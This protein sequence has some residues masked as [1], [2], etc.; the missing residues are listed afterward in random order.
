MKDK[1]PKSPGE[2]KNVTSVKKGCFKR[3]HE[4]E[5]KQEETER[6]PG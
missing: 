2:I 3:D 1:L 4:M 5:G 6:M